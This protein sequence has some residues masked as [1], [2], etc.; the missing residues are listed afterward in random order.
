MG[1]VLGVDRSVGAG[2]PPTPGYL[3]AKRERPRRT[4]RYVRVSKL[5]ELAEECTE[6][7]SRPTN[8][9]SSSALWAPYTNGPGA[10]AGERVYP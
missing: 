9:L 8:L 6:V 1:A 2:T 5:S 7:V 3:L 4:S 10:T